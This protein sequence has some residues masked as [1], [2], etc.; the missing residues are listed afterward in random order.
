[1]RCGNCVRHTN[2]TTLKMPLLR[3]EPAFESLHRDARFQEM[4]RMTLA[5]HGVSQQSVCLRLAP[6]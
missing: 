4:A 5:R 6:D 3:T 2:S 1:M